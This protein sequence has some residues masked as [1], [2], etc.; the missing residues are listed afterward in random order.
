MCRLSG[1][2][3]TLLGSRESGGLAVFSHHFVRSLSFVSGRVERKLLLKGFVRCYQGTREL[4]HTNTSV[5]RIYP[6]LFV[7]RE[8]DDCRDGTA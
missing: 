2:L 1:V 7:C 4:G 6:D 3:L 5:A 8:R